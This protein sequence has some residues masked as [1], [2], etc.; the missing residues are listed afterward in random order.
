MEAR[1]KAYR[2]GASSASG[3]YC[4]LLCNFSLRLFTSTWHSLLNDHMHCV[5]ASKFSAQHGQT[6]LPQVFLS[7]EQ[8]HAFACASKPHHDRL[9]CQVCNVFP[10]HLYM[11]ASN[12]YPMQSEW[13]SFYR[14]ATRWMSHVSCHLKQV[15][16]PTILYNS[17]GMRMIAA[18]NGLW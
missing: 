6:S 13:R 18:L 9:K 16:V 1:C 2:I 4:P 14:F 12:A 17:H 11:K 3:I 10:M 15:S 7:A 5:A 8:G